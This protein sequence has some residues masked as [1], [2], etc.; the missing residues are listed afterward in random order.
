MTNMIYDRKAG[1]LKEHSEYG[2]GA[3]SFLYENIFGRILLRVA[4]SPFVSKL[5]GVYQKSFLSRR[6]IRPF[7]K[8]NQVPVTEEALQE[9][10]CFND[11]FTRKNPVSAQ[12]DDPNVLL[13]VAD[14]KLQ[15]FPI[16]DDLRLKIKNSVYELSEILEDGELAAQYRGGTCI[17]FRLCVDDYHRYHFPDDGKVIRVKKIKGLLHTVRPISE[18]YRVFARNSRQIS[19]LETAHFGTMVQIEVGAI[20]VGKI[21]NHEKEVFSR[22]DEKGYF[23]FGGSTIV[24]LLNKPIA[25]DEDIVR[26]N[27]SGAEIQV[28][29]GE[30]IGILC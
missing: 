5:W 12:T 30:R 7:V 16:T 19:V 6:S 28:R 8:K 29:V 22:M 20:L 26:M 13:S 4:V 17:V 23:E 24:L 18:K 9:F 11:F 21:C 25:F 15:Y 1:C 2:Q 14:S 3:A 10:R 27:Q